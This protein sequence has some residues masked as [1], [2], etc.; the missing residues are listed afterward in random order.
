MSISFDARVSIPADVL[1]S[2]LAGESVILDLK[3]ESYFG[4]DEVGTRMWSAL[5]TSDCIQAA[6]DG[7]LTEYAVS[8]EELREDLSELVERLIHQGL[9]EVAGE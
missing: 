3:S 1:V 5:T 8:D 9:L 6:Y 2:Q 7:L 4:L